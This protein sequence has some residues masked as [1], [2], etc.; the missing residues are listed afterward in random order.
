MR[1]E[2]AFLYLVV[3]DERVRQPDAVGFCRNAIAGGTDVIEIGGLGLSVVELEPILEV[4]REDEALCFVR[5]DAALAQEL[6][7]DGVRL[8]QQHAPVSHVRVAVGDACLVG[9]TTQSLDT[10]RLAVETGVDFLI[11]TEGRGCVGT[12]AALGAA[13][14]VVLLRE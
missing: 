12:F 9:A 11:D 4:C 5:D 2:D 1:L 13:A 7:A 3:D 8:T 10:A 14:G 6:G